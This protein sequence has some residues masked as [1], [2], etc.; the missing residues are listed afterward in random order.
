MGENGS[1]VVRLSGEENLHVASSLHYPGRFYPVLEKKK[2]LKLQKF[3]P[4]LL[5]QPESRVTQ[6]GGLA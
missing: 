6:Q 4:F 2:C 1:L 3:Q 5:G